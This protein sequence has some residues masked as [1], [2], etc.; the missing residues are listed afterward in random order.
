MKNKLALLALLATSVNAQT[1]VSQNKIDSFDKINKIFKAEAVRAGVDNTVNYLLAKDRYNDLLRGKQ[2]HVTAFRDIPAIKNALYLLRQGQEASELEYKSAMKAV[3]KHEAEF[4]SYL[5][6]SQASANTFI[7]YETNIRNANLSSSTE[8]MTVRCNSVCQ[9]EIK[10]W[11][12][13]VAIYNAMQEIEDQLGSFDFFNVEYANSSGS[14]Q[15]VE[16][17]VYRGNW[18]PK[19]YS[20]LC[21]GPVCYKQQE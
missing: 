14:T 7:T 17:W 20:T 11:G 2:V 5:G 6:L 1:A 3:E 21:E 19:Y 4:A 9:S 10:R 13:T 15:R 12:E 16:T 18:G 8:R